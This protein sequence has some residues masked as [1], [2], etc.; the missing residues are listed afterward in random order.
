M[1]QRPLCSGTP[2]AS[3]GVQARIAGKT[4]GVPPPEGYFGLF[5]SNIFSFL[6]LLNLV[7]NRLSSW[8]KSLANR[9]LAA[10]GKMEEEPTE[11]GDEAPRR[12]G[13]QPPDRGVP[14]GRRDMVASLDG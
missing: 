5:V 6:F 14:T 10:S 11:D 9:M 8:A 13:V 12:R 7:S 1:I 3:H 4:G 2:R